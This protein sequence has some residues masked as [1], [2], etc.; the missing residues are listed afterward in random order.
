MVNHLKVK[1]L[2]VVLGWVV[3]FGIPNIG[4]GTLVCD[5][6]LPTKGYGLTSGTWMGTVAFRNFN[7]ENAAKDFQVEK[8]GN[9]KSKVQFT[10]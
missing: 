10:N 1:A 2:E 9:A 6:T 7:N 8:Y 3:L 5:A 4:E